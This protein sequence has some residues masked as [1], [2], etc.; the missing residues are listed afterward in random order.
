MLS[1][2]NAKLLPECQVFKGQITA[3]TSRLDEE[4]KREP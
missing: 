1:L 4:N 3:G 2:E